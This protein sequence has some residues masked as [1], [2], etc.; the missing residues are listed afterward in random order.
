VGWPFHS[1]SQC[2]VAE[3]VCPWERVVC[4]RLGI[5]LGEVREVMEAR[6]E[7][8]AIEGW[9]WVAQIAIALVDKEVL[10]RG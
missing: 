6:I 9:Y 4:A 3:F 8:R 7:Q 5:Y 1:R 2:I 10:G